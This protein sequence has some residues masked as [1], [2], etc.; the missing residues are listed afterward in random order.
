M[1]KTEKRD[2]S[3]SPEEKKTFDDPDK[4]RCGLIEQ[5]MQGCRVDVAKILA[6]MKERKTAEDGKAISDYPAVSEDNKEKAEEDSIKEL[7][8]FYD[9][10]MDELRERVQSRQAN[11]NC[12]LLMELLSF[13]GSNV[14][15]ATYEKNALRAL[16]RS[17]RLRPVLSAV[18]Q[19]DS[20][21]AKTMHGP[22]LVNYTSTSSGVAAGLLIKNEKADKVW[23]AV[24]YLDNLSISMSHLS[25]LFNNDVFGKDRNAINAVVR[26]VLALLEV[27]DI[28]SNDKFSK[29]LEDAVRAADLKTAGGILRYWRSNKLRLALIKALDETLGY[30]G[31]GDERRYGRDTQYLYA[32]AVMVIGRE[33]DWGVVGLNDSDM[34]DI[35]LIMQYT[36]KKKKV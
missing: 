11:I 2:V 24:C 1:K 36:V 32:L 23:T 22:G 7:M 27:F 16:D 17:G 6:T 30:E 28:Y 21:I 4:F 18:V 20:R 15:W 34:R 35:A 5:Y 29:C 14:A 9:E 26:N 3:P 25:G 31:A 10:V 19:K 13:H 12:Q 8:K 33:K